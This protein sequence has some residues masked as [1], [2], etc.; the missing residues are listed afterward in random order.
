MGD[1]REEYDA[2]KAFNKQEKEKRSNKILTY[3]KELET[4][5]KID[6]EAINSSQGHYRIY[7]DLK[8]IDVW[9]TTAK[10]TIVGSNNYDGGFKK[11]KT[12]INSFID[13]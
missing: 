12:L 1:M 10:F 11:F 6:F 7:I 9:I 2:L 5:N 3:L 8:K 13:N 4:N